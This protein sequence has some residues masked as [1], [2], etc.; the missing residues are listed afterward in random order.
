MIWFLLTRRTGEAG[1]SDLGTTPIWVSSEAIQFF[2]AYGAGTR[3]YLRSGAID[4]IDV[5]EK[6]DE[7]LSKGRRCQE[8][9]ETAG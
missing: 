4:T 3:I 1:S 5:T 7:I 8:G 6:F 9:T 2:Q